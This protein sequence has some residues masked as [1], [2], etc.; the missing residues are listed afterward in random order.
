MKMSKAALNTIISLVAGLT[1]SGVIYAANADVNSHDNTASNNNVSDQNNS[2]QGVKP[3]ADFSKGHRLSDVIGCDVHTT[4]GKEVGAIRD[5][6]V[7]P[8]S[9]VIRFVIVSSGGLFGVDN[10]LRAVPPGA[11]SSENNGQC[12]VS[13]DDEKWKNAPTVQDNQLSALQRDDR[14]KQIYDYYGQQWKNEP[15]HEGQNR[16]VYATQIKGRQVDANGRKIGDIDDLIVNL[17][18]QKVSAV[19]DPDKDFAGSSSK[20]VVSF[21][22]LTAPSSKGGPFTTNLTRADLE[23]A[24]AMNDDVWLV[25]T[26]VAIYTWDLPQE[27]AADSNNSSASNTRTAPVNAVKNAI[28]SDS[29]DGGQKIEVSAQNGHVVLTGKVKSEDA[30]DRIGNKAE[31]AANGY[32]IDNQIQTASSD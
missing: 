3:L 32:P 5:L 23:K 9:G 24:T 29:S 26:F 16:L 28:V 17:R 12:H 13:L 15:T 8:E 7:D 31:K 22:H 4:S 6:V 10:T 19:V 27:G 30:K 2:M 11:L 1:L 25:P 21:D 20:Y 14:G 18:K